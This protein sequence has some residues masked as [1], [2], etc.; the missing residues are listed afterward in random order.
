MDDAEKLKQTMSRHVRQTQI[1]SQAVR[2]GAVTCKI[3]VMK[4]PTLNRY[5]LYLHRTHKVKNK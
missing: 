1:R 3:N 4:S 2:R 5:L